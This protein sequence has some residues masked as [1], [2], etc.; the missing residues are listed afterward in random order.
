[1]SVTGDGSANISIN[2]ITSNQRHTP[3][4][5]NLLAYLITCTYLHHMYVPCHGKRCRI[6]TFSPIR[7]PSRLIYLVATAAY[8]GAQISVRIIHHL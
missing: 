2:Q 7:K 1:M 6:R 5:L 4:P 3:C 8:P